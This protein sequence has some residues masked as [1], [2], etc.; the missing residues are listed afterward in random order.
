MP[1]ILLTGAAGRLRTHLRRRFGEEGRALLATDIAQPAGGDPVELADLA[2]RDAVERLMGR[3]ISAVI[4]FG[5]ISGEAGWQSIL[6]ANIVGSYNIFEAARKAGV[7]RVIYASSYHVLGMYPTSDVPLGVDAPVRPDTLYGV[8]KVFGEAL[9]RLYFDK[10]GIE[11]LCIRICAANPPGNER[12]LHLWCD[13]DDLTSLVVAG[14]EAPV[15][16]YRTVFAISNNDGAWYRNDRDQTLGWMAQH[17]SADLPVPD[18]KGSW[19]PSDP[20]NVLQG[21]IFARWGH[22]DD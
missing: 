21:G 8:S 6:D 12:D 10:F 17:F 1:Q 3:D 14:L 13:R 20:A 11:C 19:P 9:G 4:H 2:N 15:L 18:G 7:K 16:G 22:F 5:G